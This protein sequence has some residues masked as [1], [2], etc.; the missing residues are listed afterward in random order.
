MAF[1]IHGDS[2]I[3]KQVLGVKGLVNGVYTHIDEDAYQVNTTLPLV[4][5]IIVLTYTVYS[6]LKKPLTLLMNI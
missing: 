2:D 4:E 5:V 3:K 1:I 6:S